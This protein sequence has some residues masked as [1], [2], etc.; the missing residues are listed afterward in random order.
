M[1]E[2]PPPT[3]AEAVTREYPQNAKGHFL[4]GQ[5]LLRMDKNAD[6]RTQFERATAL[7]ATFASGY[8]LAVAC[9]NM[10]DAD[11]AAKTFA[12]MLASYGDSAVLHLYFGQASLTSP[13]EGFYA[14]TSCVRSCKCRRIRKR[15][16]ECCMLTQNRI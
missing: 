6:A 8:E 4:L 7:D 12:E 16:M 15:K 2:M 3:L 13:G 10:G 14:L 1:S 9:L 11:C 5:A